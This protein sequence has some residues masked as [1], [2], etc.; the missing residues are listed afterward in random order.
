LFGCEPNHGGS[1][2]TPIIV[3]FTGDLQVTFRAR[4]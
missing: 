4:K 1:L 2:M 3:L